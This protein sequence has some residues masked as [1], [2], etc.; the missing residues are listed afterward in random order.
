[1]AA[2]VPLDPT[3]NIV[4]N[5]A[6]GGPSLNPVREAGRAAKRARAAE[7]LHRISPANFDSQ[8]LGE[9]EVFALQQTTAALA[10]VAGVAV[11]PPGF[12]WFGPAM[13]AALAPIT[14]ALAGHTATLAGHT[15]TLAGHTATLAGHT[16]TLA[17]LE[18]RVRNAVVKDPGDQITPLTNALGVLPIL[19]PP[20]LHHLNGMNSAQLAVMLN[21]FG[22]AVNPLITR[23]RRLKHYIGIV[24]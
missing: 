15:A 5:L 24:F 14:A 12:A 11:V 8:A 4:L 19:F 20:T 9:Q 16:A 21:F 22:L 17:N 2:P 1:M 10:A 13:V 23:L 18:A 3:S 7:D 6:Y